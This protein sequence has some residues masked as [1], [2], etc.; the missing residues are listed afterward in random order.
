MSPT[1]YTTIFDLPQLYL[2]PSAKE[3]MSTLELLALEPP[4]WNSQSTESKPDR[5]GLNGMMD[6][7]GLPRYLTAIV[8]SSLDWIEE[9]RREEIWEAASKR[10]SERSGRTGQSL[11]AFSPLV[12]AFSVEAFWVEGG[13]C[14]EYDAECRL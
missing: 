1:E 9:D 5:K 11:L 10:L 3:L 12:E 2:H 13:S 6:E 8:A 14:F 7:S 4:D